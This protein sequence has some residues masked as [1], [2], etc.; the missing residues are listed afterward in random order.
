MSDCSAFLTIV[1]VSEID[2][3]RTNVARYLMSIGEVGG[4]DFAV[5]G[6]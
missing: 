1:D 5:A 2:L 4:D 3:V 6:A